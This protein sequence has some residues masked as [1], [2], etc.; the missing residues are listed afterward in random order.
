[1]GDGQHSF[2][3]GG[4]ESYLY[5]ESHARFQFVILSRRSRE[6]RSD[7]PAQDDEGSQASQPA[8]NPGGFQPGLRILSSFAVL[9][10]FR[11][12]RSTAPAAQDDKWMLRRCA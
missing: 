12:S 2:F 5:V 10:R 11:A 3:L 8:L 9:R 4:L 1:M 7:G 6:S